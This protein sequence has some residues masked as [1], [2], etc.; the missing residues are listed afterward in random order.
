MICFR[1]ALVAFAAAVAISCGAMLPLESYQEV[2]AV[3]HPTQET[4]EGSREEVWNTILKVLG[5]ARVPIE[6][7]NEGTGAL[8]TGW[9]EGYSLIWNRRRLGDQ[10]EAGGTPLPAR[11]RLD[12]TMTETD[13][14][15]KVSVVADE[16]TNFL[17]LTGVDNETGQGYY[18]DDWRRTP[19]QT[20]REHEFL[21]ALGRALGG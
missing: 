13:S 10:S 2:P 6:L 11:Y 5:S 7:A 3:E 17:I 19:S 21:V 18:E 4:F 1:L 20:T 9:G 14:G 16:E 12:L 15:V 8:S